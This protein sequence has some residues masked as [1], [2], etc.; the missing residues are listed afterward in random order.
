[1][2]VPIATKRKYRQPSPA[3]LCYHDRRMTSRW[4]LRRCSS[5]WTAAS[6]S[7]ALWTPRTMTL[8]LHHPLSEFF[9]FEEQGTVARMNR[10]AGIDQRPHIGH[11]RAPVKPEDVPLPEGPSKT[12]I[13]QIRAKNLSPELTVKFRIVC[14]PSPCLLSSCMQHVLSVPLCIAVGQGCGR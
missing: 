5:A 10:I 1:M 13:W 8:A 14:A 12:K 2:A 3:S 4:N 7:S 11:H 9:H 6:S